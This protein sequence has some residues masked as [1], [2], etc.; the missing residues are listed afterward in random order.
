MRERLMF[1]SGVVLLA[2]LVALVV[3][4]GSFNFG[5]FAPSSIEQTYLFWAVSTV[6]FI[7]TVTLGFILF[8]TGVRLYVERKSNRPGSHIKWKL[9]AGALALSVVPV[10]FLVLF[11]VSVLNR[12]LETWFSRP[13]QNIRLDLTEVGAVLKQ[14]ER[15]K[16]AAQANWLAS[17]PQDESAD[18][19]E[20]FCLANRIERAE[21]QNPAGVKRVLCAVPKLDR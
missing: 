5:S 18:F 4:Q 3:W 12:N 10:F 21:I 17:L 6:I 13:A 15:D 16:L 2:I 19:Y 14:E 1:G 8:R 7:L 9:I 11:S 20:R